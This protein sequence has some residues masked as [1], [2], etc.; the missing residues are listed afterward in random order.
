[1]G[2]E[3]LKALIGS[4][5]TGMILAVFPDGTETWPRFVTLVRIL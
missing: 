4:A 1:L 3:P 2:P 5:G